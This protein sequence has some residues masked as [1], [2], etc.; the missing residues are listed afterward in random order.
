MKTP[1]PPES[2]ESRIAPAVVS[3]LGDE[4][5]GPAPLDFADQ[6]TGEAAPPPIMPPTDTVLIPRSGNFDLAAAVPDITT[7]PAHPTTALT[8]LSAAAAE[9]VQT[10]ALNLTSL[11][12]SVLG[13]EP[14]G[15]GTLGIG[16]GD[17]TPSGI[18][19]KSALQ[20][21][22]ASIADLVLVKSGGFAGAN[23]ESLL[24]VKV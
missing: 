23:P 10:A 3:G 8:E 2:L 6:Q 15:V 12:T 4:F 13:G 22:A 17:G 9:A 18:D 5:A 7:V 16:D 24:I 21:G 19:T 1:L 11:A 14:T 20:S